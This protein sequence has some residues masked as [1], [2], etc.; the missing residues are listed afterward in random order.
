MS[1]SSDDDDKLPEKH[2]TLP[3][4]KTL[5]RG[6]VSVCVH[7][8]LIFVVILFCGIGGLIKNVV[9]SGR[10]YVCRTLSITRR[11]KNNRCLCRDGETS[12]RGTS[13]LLLFIF[14]HR[15]RMTAQNIRAGAGAHSPWVETRRSF[16]HAI[17]VGR[18][19]VFDCGEK[20]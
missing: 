5:P 15:S 11:S 10:Q 13:P 6:L 20:G 12:V 1:S 16:D 2:A 4:T 3:L 17:R 14:V 19:G 18:N 8:Y 7:S 9:R